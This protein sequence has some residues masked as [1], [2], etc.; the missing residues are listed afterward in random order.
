[1]D[2][3]IKIRKKSAGI[4]AIF[5]LSK[6]GNLCKIQEYRF[7]NTSKAIAAKPDNK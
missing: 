2:G 4:T 7:Y 3:H 1:V 5:R 6:E